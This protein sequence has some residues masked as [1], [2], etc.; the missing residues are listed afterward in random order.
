MCVGAKGMCGKGKMTCVASK[1]A[2]MELMGERVTDTETHR[3]TRVIVI[4]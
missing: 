4:K 2:G 3:H 1:G